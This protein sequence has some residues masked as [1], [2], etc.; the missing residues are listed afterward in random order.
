MVAFRPRSL[1]RTHSSSDKSA[2]G[3]SCNGKPDACPLL[4]RRRHH[5][6]Q[7]LP[8]RRSKRDWRVYLRQPLEPVITPQARPQPGSTEQ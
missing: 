5:R 3:A 8:V 7:R 1:S 2:V 4:N 6:A